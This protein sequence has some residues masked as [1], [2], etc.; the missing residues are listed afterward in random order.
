MEPNLMTADVIVI[1][2][3]IAGA[4][5]A[6]RLASD[7]RV[8]ILEMET[9]PGFHATGRSAANYEPAYGPSVIRALTKASGAFFQT[10]SAAFTEGTLAVP[11][12]VLTLG[13]ADDGVPRTRRLNGVTVDPNSTRPH[14]ACHYCARVPRRIFSWTTA[15]WI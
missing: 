5:I 8:L 6:A 13:D 12:G 9:Q 14:T 3:G 10:P 15:P 4:S 1:G 7:A 2:A 11:M